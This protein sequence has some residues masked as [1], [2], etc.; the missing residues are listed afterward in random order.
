MVD[1]NNSGNIPEMEKSFNII[2][3]SLNI[4][5]INSGADVM[6]IIIRAIGFDIKIDLLNRRGQIRKM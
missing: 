5:V 1:I 6:I 4:Y 2:I 3:K